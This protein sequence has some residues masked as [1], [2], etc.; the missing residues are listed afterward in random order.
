MTTRERL[1]AA[2]SQPRPPERARYKRRT[3]KKGR[4]KT[5]QEVPV[6]NAVVNVVVVLHHFGE[7]FAQ[8]FIVGRFLKAKFPDIIEINAEFLCRITRHV[9]ISQ[10]RS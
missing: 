2:A 6:I 10:T 1:T 8:E 7:Q 9:R 5:V 4:T 3:T